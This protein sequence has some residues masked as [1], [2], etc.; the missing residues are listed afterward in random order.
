M[1]IPNEIRREMVL[2]GNREKVWSA[3][4]DP[5]RIAQWFGTRAEFKRLAV[6]E[7]II[8]GWDDEVYQ[9]LIAEVEPPRRF[10]YRWDSIT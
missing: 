7:Q 2:S 4:T 3:I 1:S 8:F 6:G 9:G 10:A 5:A